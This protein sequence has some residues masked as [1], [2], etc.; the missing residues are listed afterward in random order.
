MQITVRWQD[1]ASIDWWLGFAP[2]KWAR[3]C[4]SMP[5]GLILKSLEQARKF[6][7]PKATAGWSGTFYQYA[8]RLAHQYFLRQLNGI[9][10][11][12]V[13][14]YFLNAEDMGGPASKDRW[15]GAI[16]LVHASLGITRLSSAGVHESFVDVHELVKD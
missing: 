12:L 3:C 15:E 10:S 9:Q 11:H 7:A 2:E 13:F 4:L 5:P 14:L 1:P 6:Y 8:N 16:E